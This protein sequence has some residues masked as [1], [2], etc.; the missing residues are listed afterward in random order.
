MPSVVPTDV[1]PLIGVFDSGVGGLSIV[2]EL[3]AELPA[4][5]LLFAADQAHL[6][7]GVRPSTEIRHFVDSIARWMMGQGAQVIVLACNSASAAALHTLRAD[8]PEFPF[9]GMEPAVKPA[10]QNTRSGVIGVLSTHAT[11]SGDLF[12]ATAA[13]YAADVRVIAQPAPELVQLVEAG[14][15]ETDEGKTVLRRV[16]APML[17]AGADQIALACTHFPFLLDA[18]RKIAGE[19]VTFVDPSPAVARQTRRV[20]DSLGLLRENAVTAHHRFHTTGDPDRLQ[21]M[22][23]RLIGIDTPVHA[24]A[25]GRDLS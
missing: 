12:R 18:L 8:Y 1:N 15:W 4:H 22:I 14:A 20:L 19:G 17:E 10:A 2:R 5:P 25:W 3:F 21:E 9:V 16:I 13:R 11:A 23:R 7:Y 24:L 6:P